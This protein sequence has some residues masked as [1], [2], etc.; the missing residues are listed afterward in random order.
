MS[1]LLVVLS[2]LANEKIGFK[3]V[4]TPNRQCVHRLGSQ[5]CYGVLDSNGDFIPDLT[6]LPDPTTG[7]INRLSRFP[8]LTENIHYNERVYELKNGALIPMIMNSKLELVPEV[9]EAIISFSDYHFA[10][11]SRKI[12][13]LPGYFVLTKSSDRPLV[14]K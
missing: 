7:L 5:P 6:S 11:S 14:V 9:G 13:N 8:S 12:Y 1:I 4:P 3:F 2:W 10:T